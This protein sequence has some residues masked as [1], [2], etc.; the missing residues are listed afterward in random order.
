MQHYPFLFLFLMNVVVLLLVVVVV[1]VIIFI[2]VA[3]MINVQL[4]IS[5]T[6]SERKKERPY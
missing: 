3:D 6:I 2:V 5:T 4:N 1:V